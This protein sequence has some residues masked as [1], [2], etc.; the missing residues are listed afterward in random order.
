MFEKNCRKILKLLSPKDT[1]LDIG[2]WAIPFNRAN[3][4]VDLMPYE[5]RGIHG[6]Q[7]PDK[8]YFSKDTWIV[9]D[10]NRT[11]LPFKDKSIDF[12]T[13]SH[14]L[15][16]I[17]NPIFV[18]SEIM[19]V[20]K[21]GYIEVPSRTVETIMGLEGERF[22]GYSHHRW[23]IEIKASTIT[24]RFKNHFIHH[25]WRYHLPKKYL[26]KLQPQDHIACLFWENSFNFEE[27]FTTSSANLRAELAE[28]VKQKQAYP[29]V[30]YA[31]YSLDSSVHL[32]AFVKHLLLKSPKLQALIEKTLGMPLTKALHEESFW[33][34]IPDQHT[35]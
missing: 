23:L 4:V 17:T 1:V 32:K 11:P 5:T 10:I 15:E 3:Y 26:K 30:L 24:F 13:C 20:G 6:S 25:S 7:G 8:E 35:K 2:G 18:C 16:D 34:T 12:V 33:Q 21:K 9:Q 27:V 29:A 22:A 19:R 14:T 31:L 28:F